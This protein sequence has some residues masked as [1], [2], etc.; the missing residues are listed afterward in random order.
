MDYSLTVLTDVKLI[1]TSTITT[2]KS[3]DDDTYYPVNYSALINGNTYALLNTPVKDMYQTDMVNSLTCRIRAVATDDFKL[4]E[5][6]LISKIYW[7]I[8]NVEADVESYNADGTENIVNY[9]LDLYSPALMLQKIMVQSFTISQPIDTSANKTSL[10]IKILELIYKVDGKPFEFAYTGELIDATKD[11]DAE[12]INLGRATLLEALNALL[13]QINCTAT[14]TYTDEG[15]YLV[16]IKYWDIEEGTLT[17]INNIAKSHM[18]KDY[19]TALNSEIKQG[20]SDNYT[21]SQKGISLRTNDDYAASDSNCELVL[22]NNVYGISE[23]EILLPNL[24]ITLF[25]DGG[26]PLVISEG[27]TKFDLIDHIIEKG[28]YDMLDPIPTTWTWDTI[29]DDNKDYYFYY[30]LGSNTIN[31]FNNSQLSAL[32]FSSLTMTIILE[33]LLREYATNVLNSHSGYDSYTYSVCYFGSTNAISH[34]TSNFSEWRFDITYKAQQVQK[35]QIGKTIQNDDYKQEVVTSDAQNESQINLSSYGRSE[36]IKSDRA[37]N[38][39]MTVSA[40]ISGTDTPMEL[41]KSYNDFVLVHSQT[42]TLPDHTDFIGEFYEKY[43]MNDLWNGVSQQKR[44]YQIDTSYYDRDILVKYIL[45]FSTA[46]NKTHEVPPSNTLIN[47]IWHGFQSGYSDNY[48]IQYIYFETIDEN[49]NS[50]VTVGDYT[51]SAWMDAT[52]FASGNSVFIH[53]NCET[54]SYL[55][56]SIANNS[57][58]SNNGYAQTKISYVDDLG[59]AYLMRIWGGSDDYYS[60]GAVVNDTSSNFRPFINSTIAK[61]ESLIDDV[62]IFKSQNERLL[63]SLQFETCVD[64]TITAVDLEYLASKIII[65]HD[66]SSSDTGLYCSSTLGGAKTQCSYVI[67]D[68]GKMTIRSGLIGVSKHYLYLNDTLVMYWGNATEIRLYV[69][70]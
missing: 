18:A 27:L 38:K 23:F 45:K 55:G 16:G 49:G 68:N 8:G 1:D 22:Q 36:Q 3:A 69:Q 2:Y 52:Q 44:I 67:N 66:S 21:M 13:S 46:L 40:R 30:T 59:E 28:A 35:M 9:K 50:L 7:L 6:I 63:V 5:Y 56:R 61:A 57:S 4:F 39:I 29:S 43:V 15:V 53:F 37:G 54:N 70:R 42:A 24:V 47:S 65:K 48:A 62:V 32:G 64:D 12:D 11:V 10:F 31:G 60:D 25:A 51:G 26:L 58:Y 17:N 19:S 20:L 14:V 34:F 41:C 33:K